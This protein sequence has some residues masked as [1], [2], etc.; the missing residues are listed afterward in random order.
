MIKGG[1]SIRLGKFFSDC[2]KPLR[3]ILNLL[4]ET[5]VLPPSLTQFAL[6]PANFLQ[7]LPGKVEKFL[8]FPFLLFDLL[9]QLSNFRQ[10]FLFNFIKLLQ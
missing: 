5:F 10:P 2:S 8:D 6:K 7:P 9:T 3:Q 1:L 4:A